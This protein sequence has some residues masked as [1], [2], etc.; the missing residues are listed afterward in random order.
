MRPVA[1]WQFV[2]VCHQPC[3][4]KSVLS[5]VLSA[6]HRRRVSLKWVS[7]DTLSRLAPRHTG[8]RAMLGPS[9]WPRSLHR[10]A[11][12]ALMQ[13]DTQPNYSLI[14]LQDFDNPTGPW[15]SDWGFVQS[16]LFC[17]VLSPIPVQF[18]RSSSS[19]LLP[20][21]LRPLNWGFAKR[22]IRGEKLQLYNIN[23]CK[24]D[25]GETNKKQFS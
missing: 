9:V 4:I 11:T 25:G 16:D 2:P 15:E 23:S 19:S 17:L 5:A 10:S 22:G 7:R 18:P 12:Q 13:A 1:S 14:S 6:G 24:N 21:L 20:A 3:A 8:S